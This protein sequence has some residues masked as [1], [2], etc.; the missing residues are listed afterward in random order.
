MDCGPSTRC[1]DSTC[2]G[3]ERKRKKGKH[4]DL[5]KRLCRRAASHGVEREMYVATNGYTDFRCIGDLTKQSTIDNF[6]RSLKAKKIKKQKRDAADK[7]YREHA[8]YLRLGLQTG[9]IRNFVCHRD[10]DDEDDV[11][12]WRRE[13]SSQKPS[14][15]DFTAYD[16]FRVQKQMLALA[17]YYEVMQKTGQRPTDRFATQDDALIY[18]SEVVHVSSRT[19]RRWR[20]DFQINNRRFTER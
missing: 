5:S 8:A 10:D 17:V 4:A 16:L 18:A 7:M 12:S 14:R 20:D 3:S 11:A 13:R 19:V 15:T 1:N 6:I 9:T 2:N